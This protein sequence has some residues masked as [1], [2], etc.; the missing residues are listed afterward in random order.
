VGPQQAVHD[1]LEVLQ[2]LALAEHRLGRAV[3]QLAVEV[4]LGEAHLGVGQLGEVLQGLAR[5]PLARGD[6]FEEALDLIRIHER[7]R[8]A[9]PRRYPWES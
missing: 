4:Q 3:A 9:P 8:S 7:G 1:G 5:G 6:R 2:L